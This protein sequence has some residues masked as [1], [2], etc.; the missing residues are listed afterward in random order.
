M[1]TFFLQTCRKTCYLG[2]PA[3]SPLHDQRATT[4]TTGSTGKGT[5]SE[6]QASC[7][8][9]GTSCNRQREPAYLRQGQQEGGATSQQGH[10]HKGRDTPS[11][12]SLI[13]V[14]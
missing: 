11:K 7:T 8:R 13:S 14:F 10:H 3:C 9:T 4:T 1:K 2:N 5:S 12:E 6:H